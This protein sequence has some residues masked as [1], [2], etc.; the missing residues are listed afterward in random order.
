M[1]RFLAVEGGREYLAR[2][3]GVAQSLL[4]DA[5]LAA[6]LNWMLGRFDAEHVPETFRPYQ[7]DEIGELRKRPLVAPQTV[8]SELLEAARRAN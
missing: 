3:P 6:L 7:A 5:A 8:R 1:A 4:D 2:V